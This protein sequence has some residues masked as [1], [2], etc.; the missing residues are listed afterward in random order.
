M[1]TN[2]YFQSGVPGGRSSEQRLIEGL[3]IESIKIYGFDTYYLPRTE[4]HRDEIDLEDSLSTF[5]NAIPLE[6]YLENVD[7]FGGEGEL[8]SKFGI[9][10]RDTA[11]FVV[12]RMRWEDVVSKGRSSSLPLPNR[13]SEGD[14]I[15]MPLTDNY[16]EI[17]R[18]DALNP[19]F[20][21]GKL[22]VYKLQCE[23]YQ[24]SSERFDTGIG[25]IDDIEI[26]HSM[27]VGVQGNLLTETGF[28]LLLEDVGL[29][30]S[31]TL[32]FENATAIKQLDPL[33]NNDDFKL[34]AVADDILDFTE[35]N[36]FG[37]ILRNA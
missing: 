24:Y 10:F 37:E 12:A 29:D 35:I 30:D 6:M 31:G 25:K 26:E 5:Q 4:V 1:S 28:N 33:A 3:I 32:L 15:Y 14:L 27:D 8:M 11:T 17:K 2:F 23:L 36:P 19:F 22:Y 13:P 9:E 34:E 18:V 20:Q 7:G 21:L 16:F